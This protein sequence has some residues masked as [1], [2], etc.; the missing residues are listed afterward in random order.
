M[1]SPFNSSATRDALRVHVERVHRGAA[2]HEEPVAFDAAEADVRAA[3]RKID[4]ADQFAV[5][6]EDRNAVEALGTHAPAA[7]DVAIDVDTQPVGRAVRFRGDERTG[8]RQPA[9]GVDDVE[10][11][12]HAR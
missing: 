5:A 9:T 12:D 10:D 1:L 3:F 6:I 2:A 11:A 4:S 8:I 7:P